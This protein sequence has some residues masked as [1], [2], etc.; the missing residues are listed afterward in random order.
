MNTLPVELIAAIIAKEDKKTMRLVSKKFINAVNLNLGEPFV[1]YCMRLIQDNRVKDRIVYKDGDYS[2][3][4]ISDRTW[5]DFVKNFIDAILGDGGSGAYGIYTYIIKKTGNEFRAQLFGKHIETLLSIESSGSWCPRFIETIFT[6]IIADLGFLS[7]VGNS[8][9]L[10]TNLL[11]VRYYRYG[12]GTPYHWFR[13]T[14][15]DEDFINFFVRRST[16]YK[17]MTKNE[18]GTNSLLIQLVNTCYEPRLLQLHDQREDDID[19]TVSFSG[20]C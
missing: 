16:E 3:V 6:D 4:V 8:F 12:R 9:R 17:G 14:S 5:A 20:T 13:I 10:P 11:P 19:I 15:N 7:K 1:N 2:I 18:S